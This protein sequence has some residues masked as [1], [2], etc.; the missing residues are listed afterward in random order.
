MR[1]C[2]RGIGLVSVLILARVLT[3]EDFGIVAMATIVIGFVQGFSE[4]GTAMVL[5]REPNPSRVHCDT[6]WTI[7][8]LVGVFIGVLLAVLA[9]PAA[10]YFREPRVAP[11]LYLLAASAALGATSNVG[12][13]LVRKAL[14]F[15]TDFRF[16]VYSRLSTF[17]VTV[18]LALLWRNYWALVVGQI[19]GN[20]FS[21]GLS[22]RMHPYRPRLSLEKGRQYL[23]FSSYVIPINIAKF[24][25]ERFPVLVVGRTGDTGL[26][27]T[28]NVA[29]ELAGMA[30]QEIT[31]PLGRALF[32]SF[33][34][35][36]HDRKQLIEAFLHVLAAVTMLTIP[37][38]LGLAIIAEEFVHVVLGPQWTAAVPFLRWMAIYGLIHAWTITLTGH[39]LM[40]S[41][42]ERR[43][44][45]AAWL[46]LAIMVPSVLVGSWFW[47]AHGVVVGATLSALVSLPLMIYL[48]T[49]A[50]PV[51]FLQLARAIGP[52]AVAGILMVAGLLL[53]TR[54]L[55]DS[56]VTQLAVDVVAGAVLYVATI[57]CLWWLRGRPDGVERGV[58][59]LLARWFKRSPSL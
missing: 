55:F 42:Y 25:R 50:L 8:I 49:T 20:L 10:W 9:Q 35:L 6:A 13:V 38:S 41:G 12:M 44:T 26:L 32:P 51:T 30:T 56:R 28:F 7:Q 27:G 40:V 39:V 3:P 43:S 11:V 16:V 2:L 21:V 58:M 33:A 45:L 23:T 24:L 36:T 1:W 4:L 48:L 57:L 15:A 54:Q 14:D 52:S 29:V 5:I 34:T 17:F 53:L 22:Y 46:N 31:F 19:I 59:T 37:L 18:A 47:G